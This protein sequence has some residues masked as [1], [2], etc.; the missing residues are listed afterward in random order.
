MQGSVT[1]LLVC[2]DDSA[3]L[4]YFVEEEGADGAPALVVEQLQQF[5]EVLECEQQEYLTAA[6]DGQPQQPRQLLAQGRARVD[7]A[8]KGGD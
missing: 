7:S 4:E 1:H 8:S 2:G 3:V 5:G 6:E